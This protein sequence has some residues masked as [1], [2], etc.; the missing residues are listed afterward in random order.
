MNGHSFLGHSAQQASQRQGAAPDL[1]EDGMSL[2]IDSERAVLKPV[3]IET[4]RKTPLMRLQ[5]SR[6]QVL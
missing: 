3:A 2:R 6:D 4:P 1:W 5:H